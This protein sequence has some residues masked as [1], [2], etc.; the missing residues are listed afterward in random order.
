M[1]HLPVVC[2]MITAGWKVSALWEGNNFLQAYILVK[3]VD[4]NY[5]KIQA[6]AICPAKRK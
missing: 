2:D 6:E 4:T 1:L 5:M 3:A